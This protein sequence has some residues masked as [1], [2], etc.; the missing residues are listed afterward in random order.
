MDSSS[1]W[2][3]VGNGLLNAERCAGTARKQ[4]AVIQALSDLAMVMTN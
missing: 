2:T 1:G 3:A 4:D